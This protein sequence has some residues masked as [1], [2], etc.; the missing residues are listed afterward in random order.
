MR[1]MQRAREG[2]ERT[3]VTQ[4]DVVAAVERVRGSERAYGG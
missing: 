4:R 1:A 2:G 3:D